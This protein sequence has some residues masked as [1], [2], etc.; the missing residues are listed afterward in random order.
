MPTEWSEG[1]AHELFIGERAVNHPNFSTV[2]NNRRV[3]TANGTTLSTTALAT[4]GQ[5]DQTVTSS[6]QIQFALEL[7]F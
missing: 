2:L 3:F 4:A 7:V 1:F 5:L 6:R